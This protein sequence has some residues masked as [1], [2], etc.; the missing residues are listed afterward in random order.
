MSGHNNP[1][2]IALSERLRSNPSLLN[3]DVVVSLGSGTQKISPSPRTTDF[4]HVIL[5]GYV[6]RLWRSYMS[7]FNGQK[8]W[9]ELV[10]SVDEKKRQSYIRL[11]S[12]LPSNEPAIDNVDR[13]AEMR[14]S[15][16][17]PDMI[18]NC[19][20]TLYAL[21]ISAFFFELRCTP[22]RIR[23]GQYYCRG[24][25]RCRLPGITIVNLLKQY[26]TS[27][28][29]FVTDLETLGFY[30]GT[31]DLCG[32]CHRYQKSVDFSIHHPDEFVS[33]YV[34][35][36]TQGRRRISAFPQKIQ[37]FHTRQMLHAPFGTAYHRDM[38]HRACKSCI[39]NTPL[40]RQTTDV[41]GCNHKRR[42]PRE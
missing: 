23:E 16:H 38:Q 22:E 4:R 19:K 26:N 29:G 5:D 31:L 2:R 18:Q 36:I 32:L 41:Q 3:P 21:L 11:N 33:I 17:V 7:S 37:W 27:H 15:V 8:I 9:D 28:L 6:P 25:I 1:V 24:I 35:S 42:K 40:R 30:E 12:F 10:N 34:Q 14:E 13:M 39:S 20:R